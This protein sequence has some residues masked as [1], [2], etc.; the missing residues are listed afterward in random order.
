M[1]KTCGDSCITPSCSAACFERSPCSVTSSEPIEIS[2]CERANALSSSR[3]R[4]LTGQR[5][6]CFRSTA[7][8][9]RI[10]ASRSVRESRLFMLLQ[11]VPGRESTS[12]PGSLATTRSSGFARARTGKP[13]RPLAEKAIVLGAHALVALARCLAQ[14]FDIDDQGAAPSCL[15]DPCRLELPRDLG[16]ACTAHAED[17]GD[18]LV[19]ERE[20]VGADTVANLEQPSGVPLLERMQAIAG[21]V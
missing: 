16:H 21:D 14:A 4:A 6:P 2:G 18:V 8:S 17:D 5:A 9:A 15:Q 3:A 10:S 13:G 7:S 20:L 11:G 19:G 1:T 12:E